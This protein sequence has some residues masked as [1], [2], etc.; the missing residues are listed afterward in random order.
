MWLTLFIIDPHQFSY[1]I[2]V[3]KKKVFLTLL[4]L[5]TPLELTWLTNFNATLNQVFSVVCSWT[6]TVCF[7]MKYYLH[8]SG[9]EF[10]PPS[11][12]SLVFLSALL[13]LSFGRSFLHRERAWLLWISS[14]YLHFTSLQPSNAARKTLLNPCVILESRSNQY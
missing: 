12:F 14:L 11:P 8:I 6:E 13:G 9:D 4:N 5:R 1:K 10:H 3:I 2:S 7:R